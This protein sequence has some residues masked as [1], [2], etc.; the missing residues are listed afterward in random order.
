MKSTV[1]AF[2]LGSFLFLGVCANVPAQEPTPAPAVSAPAPSIA[3]V[4]DPATA[5]RA[6]LDTVP[7]DKHAKS[8]AYFEG[9]YWLILWNFLLNAAIAIF[10]LSSG[11]SARLRDR[12]E[13]LT[14]FK[15][16]Q[17]ALYAIA[18]LILNAVLTCP[19]S[20]YEGFYREHPSGL[21]R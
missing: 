18:F 16:M 12:V 2:L 19:L 1:A 15:A 8:D 6:W 14:R 17:V 7:A 20:V 11:I 10:L 13:R 5:T 4:T 3:P 9:G 21:S